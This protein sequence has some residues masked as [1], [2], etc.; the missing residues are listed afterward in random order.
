MSL[1]VEPGAGPAPI[2]R[3]IEAARRPVDIEVYYLASRAVLGAI[4]AEHARGIPVR[5]II[6]G[7]PYR[8]SHR[9]VAREIARLRASGAEVRTAPA[10][11]EGGYR[12]DHAKYAVSGGRALIGTANWDDSAF[13]RNREYICTSGDPRLVQALHRVFMADWTDR[14]A[15]SMVRGLSHRLV[16]SPGAEPKL[17]AII[18]Q[19]GPV[20]IEAEELGDDPALLHAIAR[21]ASLARVLLPAKLSSTDRADVRLLRRA[22]VQVRLLAVRP[23]YL[24]AKMIVGDSYGFI[25][26]EN[27]SRSSL[28]DNREVGVVMTAPAHLAT[29]RGTFRTDWRR[30]N[31][32]R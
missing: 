11:F 31:V 32:D 6:D 28:D 22:G 5:V 23:V 14:R 30:A 29:L 13:H 2:V 20:D 1:F 18:G 19:A 7:K 12:F 8:M 10:R 16:L 4:A 24:H 27:V 21:K 17:A 3:F 15:G 25:G 26:S 9:L